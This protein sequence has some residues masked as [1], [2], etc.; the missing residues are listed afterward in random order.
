M[1]ATHRYRIGLIYGIIGALIYAVLLFFRYTRFAT[2]PV[3]FGGFASISFII[4][5]IF[6]FI[7]ARARKKQLGAYAP[8]REIFQSVLL[9]ILITEIGYAIFNLVYLHYINPG[10]FANFKETT[11]ALL[12]K[13]GMEKEKVEAQLSTFDNIDKQYSIA[14]IAKGLGMWVLIDSIFGVIY[15][16]VLK[17]TKP[18]Q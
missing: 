17:K 8:F 6:F 13:G 12:V 15:A 11:R 5:L 7:A 9:T 3:S 16:S 2:D 10:F 14:N 18:E 4:M 1:S